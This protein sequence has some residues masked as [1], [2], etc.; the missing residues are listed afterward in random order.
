MSDAMTARSPLSVVFL[1][2]LLFE[3]PL[4]VQGFI[5][6]HTLP[7]LQLNNTTLVFIKVRVHTRP[8]TL[9]LRIRVRSHLAPHTAVLRARGGHV[10]QLTALLFAPR[11]CLALTRDLQS[12]S[13]GNAERFI[14]YSFG[15]FLEAY[16]L[17]PEVLLGG[18]HGFLSLGILAWWQGTVA[19][20]A[21][22]RK[23]Q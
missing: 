13:P 4:A 7:F 6:P 19:Y 8:L 22:A 20:A 3:T 12:S 10:P 11:V 5:A 18:L 16:K 17:T 15:P 1:V 2:H 9:L 23:M 14:P 21:A